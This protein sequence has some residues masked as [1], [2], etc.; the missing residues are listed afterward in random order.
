MAYTSD[1]IELDAEFDQLTVDSDGEDDNTDNNISSASTEIDILETYA[2]IVVDC[3]KNTQL[4]NSRV[5]L[6]KGNRGKKT[7]GLNQQSDKKANKE[8]DNVAYKRIPPEFNTVGNEQVDVILKKAMF[9]KFKAID[10]GELSAQ[11]ERTKKAKLYSQEMI[12][13]EISTMVKKLS[14]QHKQIIRSCIG[15]VSILNATKLAQFEEKLNEIEK[16]EFL[17]NL[18]KIKEYYKEMCTCDVKAGKILNE[19][20][21]KHTTQ[22]NKIAKTCF[23]ILAGTHKKYSGVSMQQKFY[24]LIVQKFRG[25]HNK[26]LF[27][28][29]NTTNTVKHKPRD[30]S[31]W[32]RGETSHAENYHTLD[33]TTSK[34][35]S[36]FGNNKT[37]NHDR[38]DRLDRSGSNTKTFDDGWQVQKS[39]S[40]FGTKETKE[41]SD[42]AYPSLTTKKLISKVQHV[43]NFPALGSGTME[44][45]TT[46]AGCW[47]KKSTAIFTPP[48]AKKEKVSEI[49]NMIADNGDQD[50]TL[51]TKTDIAVSQQNTRSTIYT[52]KKVTVAVQFNNNNDHEEDYE[53]D[54]DD[55]INETPISNHNEWGED[56]GF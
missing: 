31:K 43:D 53:E 22:Y 37:D 48:E 36:K 18:E 38:L 33:D 8:M 41:S 47:G 54:Y 49:L 56:D 32:A 45:T 26:P 19:I 46:I 35:F 28:T 24:D 42:D 21:G 6:N 16:T 44:K 7:S 5:A 15:D 2:Q 17:E 1:I 40:K 11:L 55:V 3:L 20:E 29:T 30:Q 13:K 39:R 9:F 4:K 12:S 23:N 52:A 50:M 14:D 10:V 34:S 51:L 27:G 25:L